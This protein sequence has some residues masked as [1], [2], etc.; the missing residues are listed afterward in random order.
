MSWSRSSRAIILAALLLGTG[1]ALGA[2]SFQPVYGGARAAQTNLALNYSKPNSRLEQII[3]Q[4][5]AL[6]L[7]NSDL[8]SAQV[9][10][11]SVASGGSGVTTM[12]AKPGAVDNVDVSLTATLT[13]AQ[14]GATTP[15]LVLTRTATAQYTTSNQVLA[16]TEAAIEASERAARAVAESLR[17]AVLAALS[18]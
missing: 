17:L 16:N 14:P 7:G 10:T 8:P 2:C 4:E 3:Y 5:L 9:A 11:V 13:I 6:R 12:T 1:A 15:P 18:R